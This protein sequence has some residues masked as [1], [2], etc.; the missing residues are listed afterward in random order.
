MITA[1][2]HIQKL[3]IT[4]ISVS[5]CILNQQV[6]IKRPGLGCSKL[7][8]LLVN[9]SLKFQTLISDICQFF[10]VEKK[11][12]SFSAKASLIFSTKN[13]GVFGYKVVKHLTN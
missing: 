7:K 5:I 2:L 9:V 3:K 12:R 13:I 4:C 10:F 6:S 1:I 11:V 8:M